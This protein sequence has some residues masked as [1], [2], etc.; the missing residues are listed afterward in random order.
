LKSVFQGSSFWPWR[1]VGDNIRIVIEIKGIPG[2][3]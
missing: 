1:N 3:R 2:R